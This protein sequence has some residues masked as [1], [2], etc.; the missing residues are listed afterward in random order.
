MVAFGGWSGIA[1]TENTIC[2]SICGRIRGMVVDEGGRSTALGSIVQPTESGIRASVF[3][4]NYCT[5]I[6]GQSKSNIYIS[7]P[8]AGPCACNLKVVGSSL[9]DGEK[10]KI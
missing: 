7:N 10:R 2:H 5:I 8:A 9:G 6:P 3:L 1:K 4:L